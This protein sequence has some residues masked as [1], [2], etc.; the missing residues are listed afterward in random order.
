[1]FGGVGKKG[2]TAGESIVE[3]GETPWG[4]DFDVGFQSVVGQLETDLVVTFACASV[5]DGL[6]AFFL[7]DLDLATGDDGTG[8]GCSEEIDAL[9]LIIIL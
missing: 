4:D 2:L 7:C 1:L 9:L 5:R 8:E 6:A 3:F